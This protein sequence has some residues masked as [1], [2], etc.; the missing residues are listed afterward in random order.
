MLKNYLIIALR[1]I[2]K[3]K[4]YSLLNIFGL[5]IGMTVFILIFLYVRYELSFDRWHQNADSIYRV[6][7]KQP[8]NMYLGSDRF[9][10]TCAPLAGALME[11]YPEVVA[12]T[13]ID[14]F[15]DT[16]F[17]YREKHFVEKS[18]LWADPNFFKVFSIELVSGDPETA[19]TNPYSIILSESQAEKY[20]G[21]ENPM[22]KIIQGNTKHDLVV[23]GV[24][25]A[26]PKNSHFTGDIILP[27]DAQA[28]FSNR[29][30]ETWGSNSYY[31]YFLLQ[32]GA[33]PK[34]LEEKLPAF[35]KK[36]SGGK[37]WDSAEHYLQPLTRIHLYSNI[38]FEIAPNSDIKYI[39]LFSS[40]ALL[41]LIIACINYINL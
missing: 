20:F 32:D 23:T 14:N 26:F 5:A 33:D 18:G 41:I 36:Y 30:L 15:Q 24:F 2:K 22:G 16:P 1:N 34:A 11:E 39:Y 21:H 38:N 13:R 17:S 10:V 19:L 28:E 40:I 4:V 12:A 35:V 37:G 29:N 27:F 7:Q 3:N 6:V 31:T 8:G 9:A 25:K